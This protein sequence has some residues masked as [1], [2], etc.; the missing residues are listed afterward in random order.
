MKYLVSQDFVGNSSIQDCLQ[1][2]ERHSGKIVGFKAFGPG[3]GNPNL[4][5]EF[6][7]HDDAMMFL[8]EMSP[9]ESDHFLKSLIVPRG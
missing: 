2:I 9:D 5:I 8:K 3:G 7:T 6:D 1:L 4:F